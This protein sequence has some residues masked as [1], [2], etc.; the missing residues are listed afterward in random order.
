MTSTMNGWFLW[1]LYIQFVESVSIGNKCPPVAPKS[2]F[3]CAGKEYHTCWSVGVR[4]IDCPGAAPCCFDGCGNHCLLTLPQTRT[5]IDPCSP[6]PCGPGTNCKT[7]ADGNPVCH[8]NPGLIPKPDT[9]NGC[10]PEC[11][12]DPECRNGLVCINQRCTNRPDPCNPSPCGPGTTCKE[13]GNGNPVCQCQSGLVPKPDTIAGCGPECIIDPDCRNGQVCINQR[14]TKKPDPCDPSP[15]GPGTTCR[16]NQ[17]GNPV[18]QCNKGLVPKPDT[19]TGCG[20]ECFV[21]AEC[22]GGF[23]CLNQKCSQKQDPCEPSPCGP[24]TICKKSNNGNP[25]CHCRAGLIPKPDTITGCGPECVTDRDCHSGLICKSSKCVEKPDPC[26][27][28]PCGPN[29]SCKAN[30]N[31][32]PVCHCLSDFIPK[33]DTITG[34]GYECE[35]DSDC[36]SSYICN[37]FKCI[38]KPDPCDPSPCGPG[39]SCYPNFNGNPICKCL[40]GLVPKPDTITGCGP[41]C[42]R[43]PDCNRGYICQT[44]KCIEKPDPCNPSPCGPGAECMVNTSGNPICRCQKGLVPKPDTITGCGPEC[45]IDSD[46]DSG[47]ICKTQTCIVRPDPC[48]P[49]PCGDGAICEENAYGN[50]TCH[51]KLGLIPKPDPFIRCGPE[52]VIDRD[53]NQGYICNNTKCVIEPD[54]CQPS[55]CGIGA[56]CTKTGRSL[57][58]YCDCPE[59]YFGDPNVECK[60]IVVIGSVNPPRSPEPQSRAP[61]VIGHTASGTSISSSLNRRPVVIGGSENNFVDNSEPEV[62]AIGRRR[63]TSSRTK[64]VIGARYRKSLFY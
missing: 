35:R 34:C 27:P 39:T 16:E 45:V 47:Y 57:G 61:F 48:D 31:G 51:C 28:S 43:D 1:F 29:T 33:P 42:K 62:L 22:H 60:K 4:D 41:E 55:P 19:I 7:N 54:P 11:T 40:L 36:Q 17:N 50:P 3:L 21:D 32:N 52:C 18:C 20:P 9:I 5:I 26:V 44:G 14:C 59:K 38:V 10:G 63:Q 25:V 2:R 6:S 64:S 58:F 23:V 37:D 15:C 13:N 30:I 56:L 49:S 53:C 24:G 46:C 8:C 12:I